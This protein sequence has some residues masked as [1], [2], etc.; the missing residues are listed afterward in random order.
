MIASAC[1]PTAVFGIVRRVEE[2]RAVEPDIPIAAVVPVFQQRSDEF[3][4]FLVLLYY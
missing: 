4:K 1:R 3:E 2:L